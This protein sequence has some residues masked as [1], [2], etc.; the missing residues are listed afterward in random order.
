MSVREWAEQCKRE[1]MRAPIIEEAQGGRRYGACSPKGS[2]SR[3]KRA[4]K[5]EH[6]EDTEPVV[7]EE[8][9]NAEAEAEGGLNDHKSQRRRTA[10]ERQWA[11]EIVKDGFLTTFDPHNDWLPKDM[12]PGDYTPEFGRMLKRMYW[13]SCGFGKVAWYGADM[14]DTFQNGVVYLTHWGKAGDWSMINGVHLPCNLYG[15]KSAIFKSSDR[16]A[17]CVHSKT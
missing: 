16:R 13:R 14:K 9:G 12:K 17:G 1:D 8:E 5:A 3:A 6:A 4:I 2:K 11:K 15:S 10:N 7:T